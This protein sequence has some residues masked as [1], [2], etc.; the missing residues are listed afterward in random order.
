MMV[1]KF[2]VPVHLKNRPKQEFLLQLKNSGGLA[3]DELSL[4][5]WYASETE[6]FSRQMLE[7]EQAYIQEQI[8]TEAEEINDSGLI[9]VQ[10]FMKRSRYSHVIYLASL[11]ET[12]LS[13]ACKR[14]TAALGENITFKLEELSAKSW[15]RERKYLERYGKFEIPDHIWKPFANIYLVRNALVHENGVINVLF[16]AEREKIKMKYKDSVGVSVEGCEIEI[17]SSYIPHA[18]STLRSFVEFVDGKLGDV[19]DRSIRLKSVG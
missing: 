14:L 15:A 4:F 12:Y 5:E 16:E 8:A 7:I 2:E 19:I 10:Y 9:P 11:G 13:D 17:E 6:N 3:D 1:D 18:I